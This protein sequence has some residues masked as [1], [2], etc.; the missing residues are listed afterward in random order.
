MQVKTKHGTFAITRR[1]TVGFS[2]MRTKHPVG[3]RRGRVGAG[4]LVVVEHRKW[5]KSPNLIGGPWCEY[6]ATYD[7]KGRAIELPLPEHAR[8]KV[9]FI[10][11]V[12][13]QKIKGKR[14]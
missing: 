14:K 6:V 4:E 11:A 2:V 5:P 3:Y 10:C 9:E 7:L 8:R 1:A 12:C 13:G